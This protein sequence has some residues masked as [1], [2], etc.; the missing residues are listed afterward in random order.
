MAKIDRFEDLKCWKA[1]RELVKLVFAACNADKL[2]HDYA[3]SGQLKR[4]AI[5]VMNNTAEGFGRKSVREF[6]RFLEIAQSSSIEVRSMTYILDDMCFLP[7]E[8]VSAI[9]AKAEECKALVLGLIR[10]LNAKDP[11]KSQH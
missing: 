6:I 7:T 11:H 8:T 10:Y 4:A 5:S 3:L 9:R 2:K 1:A